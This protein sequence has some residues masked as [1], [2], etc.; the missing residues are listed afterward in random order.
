MPL[1]KRPAPT[2]LQWAA[3]CA[4]GALNAVSASGVVSSYDLINREYL[5]P[6]ARIYGNGTEWVN[7]HPVAVLFGHAIRKLTASECLCEG[8]VQD[9]TL[10]YTVVKYLAKT[11]ELPPLIESY[12]KAGRWA[13]IDATLDA[14]VLQTA[15]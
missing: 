6:T 8:C 7:H 14:P 11:R 13:D 12:M 4:I 5:W 3:K 1:R 2:T 9:F 15:S 10:A